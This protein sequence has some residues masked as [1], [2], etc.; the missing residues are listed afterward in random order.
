MALITTPAA[1]VVIG[2]A[3]RVHRALGPGL[4]ES[5]YERCLIHEF[6]RSKI[7]F[8]RQY[9]VPVLYD[10]IDVGIGFRADFIIEREVLLEIKSIDRLLPVHERQ[11][12][13]YMKCCG[14]K[15][16]LLINFN[17]PLLKD[18]IRSFVL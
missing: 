18:G 17:T 1:T 10:G 4:F 16:G 9:A 7:S 14:M 13:T 8:V 11:V 12:L 5:V 6:T 15:K 3:I 2:C